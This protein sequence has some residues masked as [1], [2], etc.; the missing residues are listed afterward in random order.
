MRFHHQSHAEAAAGQRTIG[1][2]IVTTSHTRDE[3][4]LQRYLRKTTRAQPPEVLGMAHEQ[5]P[6][7]SPQ[8]AKILAA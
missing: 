2:R 7:L 1:N 4:C 8:T 3:S 5:A 6:K